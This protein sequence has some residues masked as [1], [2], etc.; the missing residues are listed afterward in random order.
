MGGYPCQACGLAP[1]NAADRRCRGCLSERRDLGVRCRLWVGGRLADERWLSAFGEIAAD[2]AAKAI[3]TAQGTIVVHAIAARVP[4][5]LE[6]WD[7]ALP[8]EWGVYTQ[9]DPAARTA[10]DAAGMVADYCPACHDRQRFPLLAVHTT[11]CP[12]LAVRSER[13]G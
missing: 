2:R 11:G 4:W 1:E 10:A 7:P 8:C 5:M 6:V 3:I 9:G 12:L 13:W